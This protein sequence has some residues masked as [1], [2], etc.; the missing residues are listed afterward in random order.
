MFAF[1]GSDAAIV[2]SSAGQLLSYD[3]V[4]S[5]V[6]Q[7]ALLLRRP[8]KALVLIFCDNSLHSV[9]FYLAAINSDHATALLDSAT[10]DHK[11]DSLVDIYKPE[12][13]VVCGRDWRPDQAKYTLVEQQHGYSVWHSQIFGQPP[14]P[15]LCLLLSTSGS[16]G[17]AKM[18]R[19]SKQNLLS[20]AKAINKALSV[21]EQERAVLSLPIHYSYGLSILNTHLLA[22]ASVMLTS[23]SLTTSAFWSLVREN[24]CTSFAGVPYSYE[25]L[26]R[27]GLEKLHLDKLKTMTQAGGKLSD[28]LI[29]Y[30]YE[31]MALRQGNFYVMYGQTEATARI[32]ILP[33]EELPSR[34][35][36]VG[37]AIDG[38]KLIIE[39]GRE[40]VGEIVYQ[41][42]NV[43]LGYA[44]TRADLELGDL[45]K[46]RLETGDIGYL[47]EQGF[48]FVTG[49]ARRIAKIFGQRINLDEVELALHDCGPVAAI[50]ND[51][52]LYLYFETLAAEE[53]AKRRS[54]LS[55][56]L[57]LHHS[58][59]I[60]RSIAKIPRTPNG[61]VDYASLEAEIL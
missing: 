46:G 33:A 35:G 10:D 52:A 43:M 2:D 25:I 59:I 42:P 19:L 28:K 4:S 14:H 48:L 18:V 26:R 21:G 49:R 3:Q 58:A 31:F 60:T 36:S 39:G 15:D 41:G 37:K 29:S 40:G 16:T 6:D 11:K 9:L 27:L 17:S 47:D 61:K 32:S 20:N 51:Q 56:L 13:I 50:S 45:L 24:C 22:G 23:E 57:H 7:F 5:L 1:S 54:V 30:F 53:M 55:S 8:Q 12:T 38:G 34:I 44:T